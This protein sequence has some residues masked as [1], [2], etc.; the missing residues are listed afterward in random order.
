MLGISGIGYLGKLPGYFS[1]TL[2][3]LL[4]IQNWVLGGIAA[5]INQLQ[6]GLILAKKVVDNKYDFEYNINR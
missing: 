6:R 3:V 4:S 5:I 1:E 2:S